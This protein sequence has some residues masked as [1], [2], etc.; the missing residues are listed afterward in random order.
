MWDSKLESAIP[1]DGL[2]EVKFSSTRSDIMA[3]DDSLEIY[4]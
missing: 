2:E 4:I 3:F 1:A